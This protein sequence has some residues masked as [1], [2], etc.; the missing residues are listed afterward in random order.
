MTLLSQGSYGGG[1]KKE[2][3]LIRE[4]KEFELIYR[5]LNRT[6]KIEVDVP[7]I[8]FSQDV[9]VLY[10]HGETKGTLIPSLKI[11]GKTQNT[12]IL[13]VLEQED[14]NGGRNITRPFCMYTL[15]KI[16]KKMNAKLKND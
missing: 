11:I 13:E 5:K 8:D 6:K 16:S 15:T 12:I 1:I 7:Y 2:L 3:K 10:Q 4:S 14:K 9:V